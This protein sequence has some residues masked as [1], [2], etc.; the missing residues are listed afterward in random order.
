MLRR[1]QGRDKTA[2]A[3]GEQHLTTR[4]QRIERLGVIG[5]PYI[6]HDQQTRTFGEQFT[7]MRTTL[8]GIVKRLRSVIKHGGELGLEACKR[9]RVLPDGEPQDALQ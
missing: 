4:T 3:R 1:A 8:L 6:V 5:L 7:E 9:G 2:V